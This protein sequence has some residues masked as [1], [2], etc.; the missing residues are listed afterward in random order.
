MRDVF[1]LAAGK[2]NLVWGGT[3]GKKGGPFGN[4]ISFTPPQV[5]SVPGA[6]HKSWHRRTT[7][8]VSEAAWGGRGALDEANSEREALSP[9][10][11]LGPYPAAKGA[12]EAV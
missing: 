10:R 9:T 11:K 12:M 6:W 4:S 1:P 3:P 2:V 5:C 8:A 7:G